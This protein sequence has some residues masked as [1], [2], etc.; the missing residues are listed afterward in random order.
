[1]EKLKDINVSITLKIIFKENWEPVQVNSCV[2][3]QGDMAGCC[4]HSNEISNPI[5]CRE[6]FV[7]LSFSRDTNFH[8]YA[9]WK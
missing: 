5:T 9:I 1:M 2:S 7:E 3:R 8:S 4:D 6:F